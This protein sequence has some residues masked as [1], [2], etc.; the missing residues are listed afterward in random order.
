MRFVQNIVL[1]LI[2][3]ALLVI[4]YDLHRFTVAF[5]GPTFHSAASVKVGFDPV[6][7]TRAQRDKRLRAEARESILDTRAMFG[8]L[9]DVEPAPHGKPSP[10]SATK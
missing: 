10:N 3:A 2:L 6:N 4:A 7:E 1:G 9:D 8:A 5:V